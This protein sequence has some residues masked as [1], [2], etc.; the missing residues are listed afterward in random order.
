MT[1]TIDR[2]SVAIST[3][4]LRSCIIESYACQLDEDGKKSG[5]EELVSQVMSTANLLGE[6]RFDHNFSK[7]VDVITVLTFGHEGEQGSRRVST[8][9][10]EPV[11]VQSAII[12]NRSS[13]VKNIIRTSVYVKTIR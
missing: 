1:I 2:T 12:K 4:P 8:P 13:G 10:D 6:L 7:H 9:F 5:K 3:F 11:E